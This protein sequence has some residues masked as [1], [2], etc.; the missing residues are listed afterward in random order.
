MIHTIESISAICTMLHSDGK[1]VVLA[2]GFFD[3]L[4]S[5]HIN[6]LQKAREVGDVLIVAVESDERA[7]KIKGEGRPVESQL[8][9][10]QKVSQY[11][12]YVIALPANFDNFD[13]YDSLMSA[14]KP[15]IYAISSHANHQKSKNFLSEK[16]GG[17]LVVVHNFNPEVSTTQIIGQNK[18]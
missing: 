7:Y 2:T 15:E 1:K 16:Y 12:D 14:I 8:L 3:L 11:A 5:E 9:R 18:V 13:A 6:F 17:H 4:H 10:C